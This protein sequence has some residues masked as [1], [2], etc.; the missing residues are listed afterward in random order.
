MKV[1]TRIYVY[2]E[3]VSK[4]RDFVLK[5]L[6]L[7]NLLIFFI[8]RYHELTR[9]WLISEGL[10]YS[11]MSKLNKRTLNNLDKMEKLSR[12]SSVVGSDNELGMILDKLKV[13]KSELGNVSVVVSVLRQVCRDFKSYFEALKEWHRNKKKFTGKPNPPKV[14]DFDK[15]DKFSVEVMSFK[16]KGGRLEIKLNNGKKIKVKIPEFVGKVSSVRVVYFLGF[17]YVDVVWDKFIPELKP[18]GNKRAAIDLGVRNFVTLVS[19]DKRIPSIVI[20]SSN[21]I[22][23]NQWYNKLLTKLRSEHD[24]LKKNNPNCEEVK[25][26]RKRIRLLHLHRKQ[27]MESMMHEL[28]K[29]ITLFLHKTGHSV[30]YIGMNKDWKRNVKLGKR[31]NQIFVQLPFRDFVNKLKY[32]CKWLGIEVVEVDESYTSKCSCLSDDIF[33]VRKSEGKVPMSGNRISRSLFKDMKLG[34]V[35]HADVNAAFNILRVGAKIKEL[36]NDIDKFVMLKL[37]NPLVY[38]FR[39]FCKLVLCKRQ[40]PSPLG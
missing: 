15:V 29:A 39:E 36:F 27:W 26:L 9:E 31:N 34:K 22:A 16:R 12:I 1:V 40:L 19:E 32:K 13:M 2:D 10:L 23:F 38:R 35:F 33:E 24:K 3:R 4:I 6:E 5:C 30:V 14:K 28:S 25:V 20:K 8:K 37:C 17:G 18:L 21:V 11:L 7:R